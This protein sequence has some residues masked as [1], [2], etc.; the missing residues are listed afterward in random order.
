MGSNLSGQ[1]TPYLYQVCSIWYTHNSACAEASAEVKGAHMDRL[2]L[3][4]F[5]WL[6][7]VLYNNMP[8]I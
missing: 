5:Q 3:D 6:M 8:A 1:L 7:V 4:H 2:I